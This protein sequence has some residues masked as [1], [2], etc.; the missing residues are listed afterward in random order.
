MCTNTEEPSDFEDYKEHPIAADDE[1]IYL[2]DILVPFV[3]HFT[4][5]KLADAMAVRHGDNID[6]DDV[7]A[8]GECREVRRQQ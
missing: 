4:A 3:D 1:V 2:P 5:E 7:D 6:C 8:L